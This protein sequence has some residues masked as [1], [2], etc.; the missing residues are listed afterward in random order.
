MR[1]SP[2]RLWRYAVGV[3]GLRGRCPMTA[4][5]D[6]ER[7]YILDKQEAE[8]RYYAAIDAARQLPAHERRA[9]HQ[10]A[11]DQLA[12]DYAEAWRKVIGLFGGGEAGNS[13]SGGDFQ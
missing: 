11:D 7:Q 8:R 13:G 10:A 5:G 4:A 2:G 12:M 9:A 6:A 3:A 1:Y